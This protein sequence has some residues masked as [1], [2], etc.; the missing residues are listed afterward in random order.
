MYR[1]YFMTT[2][3]KQLSK[4]AQKA[5]LS[6][7]EFQISIT[8]KQKEII[9]FY[10]ENKISCITGDPGT[11]K[12]QPLDAKIYTPNG[13]ISMGDVN[14]GDEILTMEG[15][16]KVIEIFPQGEVEIFK[17]HFSDGTFSECCANHLWLTRTKNERKRS[18]LER[19]Y[20]G[21]VIRD[22]KCI[23]ESLYKYDSINYSIPLC[24]LQ[25]KSQE[26]PIP[27]YTLGILI[28]DGCLRT[29]VSF[30]TSDNEVV[31]S[32]SNELK[33]FSIKKIPSSK[34]DYIISSNTLNKDTSNGMIHP[35][36]IKLSKLNLW[37]KLSYEKHIPDIYIHNTREVRI[38]LLRGLMDS[39][40]TICKRNGSVTFSSTSTKLIEGV[41]EIV[42]S[43]GGI[44]HPPIKKST[45][46]YRDSYTITITLPNDI[47][48]FRLKR[49]RTL[50]KL[51]TKYQP[52]KYIVNV[53]SIGFKKAQCIMVNSNSHTYITDGMN[54][55]HN[56]FTAV[57][58]ALQMLSSG[59]ADVIILTKP[60]VEIGKSMGFLPGT[61][62]EKISAYLKSYSDIFED[63]VGKDMYRSLLNAGKIIFEPMN[64][65]RGVSY[66]YSIVIADECQNALLHELVTFST[67]LSSTSKLIMLGDDWQSD[68]RNSGFIP[69][70]SIFTSI[71]TISHKHLGEDFQMR[72]ELITL[73]YREYKNYLNKNK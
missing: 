61:E 43:L 2:T 63:I 58:R 37:G 16:T 31:E 53:E 60:L 59:E 4:Y 23:S 5:G 47:N 34:Y 3:K 65:C 24:E 6:Q 66:K 70:I 13:F 41:S 27:A 48:P 19:D 42:R 29:N 15:I 9:N 26:I 46:K 10:K 25:F 14:V 49:K 44:A 71:N 28:G 51:K 20:S 22:T 21:Y 12:A 45:E 54:V 35:L 1:V 8:Q 52:V 32:V 7:I 56:T 55:T 40:G 11:G 36:K 68:I 67:R 64:F 69:F 62:K 73:M 39:D 72:D 33:G 17:V 18:H 50:V 30:S 38:D 57:Y